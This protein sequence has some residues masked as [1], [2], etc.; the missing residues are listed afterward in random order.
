MWIIEHNNVAVHVLSR[1]QETIEY[2][3]KKEFWNIQQNTI[4]ALLLKRTSSCPRVSE[5][6]RGDKPQ[7]LK[8]RIIFNETY[9]WG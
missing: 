1:R 5:T 7:V 9:I 3:K 6:P 8:T 2:Y 4:E